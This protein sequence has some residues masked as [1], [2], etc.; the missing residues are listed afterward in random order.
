MNIIIKGIHMDVTPAVDTYIRKKAQGFEK[1]VDASSKLEVALSKANHH[2]KS[3]D[4]FRVQ[5]KIFSRGEY[6]QSESGAEDLY[7]AV[8]TAREDLFT[9][10]ASKKDKKM[11]LW[12]RGGKRLKN[13]IRG[14]NFRKKGQDLEI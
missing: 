13:L 12:R 6:V 4:A 8:D 1:F 7:S 5:F 11:T 10:L 2:Q 3:D 14:F 9:T